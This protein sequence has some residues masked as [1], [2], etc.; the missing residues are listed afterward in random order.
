[1]RYLLDEL[2]VDD[3]E[4]LAPPSDFL[5]K[6][7]GTSGLRLLWRGLVAVDL[8]VKRICERRPY[9]RQKGQTDDVHRANLRDIERGMSGGNFGSYLERCAESLEQID[10]YEYPKPRIGV[11]GDVYTRINPIANQSLFHK[12]EELGCEVWPAPSF[13]DQVDFGTQKT[14]HLSLKEYRFHESAVIGLLSLKKEFETWRTKRSLKNVLPRSSEPGFIE[15]I[16]NSSPYIG[17]DNNDL[18]ILNISKIVDFI[19]QGADGVINAI[20]FNCMLGTISGAI[21][22]RIRRDFE[23]IPIPTLVF[24]DSD[25]SSEKT[26]LEAFVYQVHQY[27]KRKMGAPKLKPRFT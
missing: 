19:K 5:N 3:L 17:Y 7:I 2:R 16:E 1:M 14:L 18:L 4:V 22:T 9:E 24:S 15:I 6:L 21:A 10:T 8:L 20:C 13:V 26:K 12:L 23:D 25:I 27:S 11:A